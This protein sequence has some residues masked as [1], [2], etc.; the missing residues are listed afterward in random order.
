MSMSAHTPASPVTSYAPGAR[1]LERLVRRLGGTMSHELAISQWE[2]VS[3]ELIRRGLAE[4]AKEALESE[5]GSMDTLPR[6]DVQSAWA[7]V[8]TGQDWPLNMTS[9]EAAS[10]FFSAFGAHLRSLGAKRLDFAG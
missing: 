10:Q 9:D 4:S 6:G 5:K 7:Y 2:L 8:V 1:V 3:A